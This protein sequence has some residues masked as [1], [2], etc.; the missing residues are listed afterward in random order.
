MEKEISQWQE[1]IIYQECVII[2]GIKLKSQ[3]NAMN[4]E[5]GFISINNEF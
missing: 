3:L 5:Y 2:I 4:M 1:L